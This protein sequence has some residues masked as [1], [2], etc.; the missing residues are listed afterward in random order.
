VGRRPRRCA[1]GT[2]LSSK[3]APDPSARSRPSIGQMPEHSTAHGDRSEGR[4]PSVHAMS[5]KKSIITPGPSRPK[6]FTLTKN[7]WNPP[8]IEAVGAADRREARQPRQTWFFLACA[9]ETPRPGR[10]NGCQSH[11]I[12]RGRNPWEAELDM[13]STPAAK[14]AKC[15]RRSRR[16]PACP[17]SSRS[18]PSVL[19][20]V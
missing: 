20:R 15:G 14:K 5:H 10:R 1:S 7:N 13:F 2:R 19:G 18:P 16:A 17:A 4:A 12:S 6:G 3:L 8:C 11:F 9:E